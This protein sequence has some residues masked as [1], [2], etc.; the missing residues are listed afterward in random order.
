MPNVTMTLQQ[1]PEQRHLKGPTLPTPSP[2]PT[3][4]T[5]QSVADTEQATRAAAA[6]RKGVQ[7]TILGGALGGPATQQPQGGAGGNTILGS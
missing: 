5:G 2:P 6:R 3:V 4:Q 7:Q 1:Q